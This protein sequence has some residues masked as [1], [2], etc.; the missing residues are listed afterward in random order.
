MEKPFATIIMA[1]GLGKRMKSDLPKVLHEIDN[2]PMVHFVVELAQ[3]IGSNKVVLI[4][5]HKRELVIEKTQRCNV[6]YAVQDQQ[7]GT[8]HAVLMCR[9]N[10]KDYDG[11]ALV[12][13]GDVPLLRPESALEALKLHRETEAYA[14][15]FTFEPD[16]PTGYGRIIRTDAGEVDYIVEH[17]DANE[18]ELK[19]TEV[20]GGIYFFRNKDMFEALDQTSN[21]NASGEYYITDTIEILRKAGKRV[22]AYLVKDEMEMAGANDRDQLLELEQYYLK[23]RKI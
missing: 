2:K 18:E 13:S 4:I 19:A 14:T 11:D 21:D 12:L 22:S 8:G 3:S 15:V 7:L 17:K 6:E 9:D 23:H 10:M 16:D 5:G 20:N 1:A